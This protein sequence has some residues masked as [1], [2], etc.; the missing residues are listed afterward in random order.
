MMK[1]FLWC[2][3]LLSINLYAIDVDFKLFNRG[4]AYNAEGS[5]YSD[6]ATAA[7]YFENFTETTFGFYFNDL[8][9]LRIGVAVF[10]PFSL[11]LP[12]GMR[13]F[14]IITSQI[15]NQYV[16]FTIGTMDSDHNFPAPL[17]DPLITL[18]P[19]VR[20][21]EGNTRIPN[22]TEQ[23]D[24]GKF[25][26]GYY[27]YGASF[28]WFKGGSGEIFMNWQ[29]LH[30]EEHR[31][32]FDVGLIYALDFT[33]IF[34]PYVGVRYWH[35]GGK[36]YPIVE[37]STAI[38][39]NYSGGIGIH[40]DMLSILYLASFDS[41]TRDTTDLNQFGHGLYAR[42]RFS[43]LGW[44]DLE[45]SVFV[46]GYYLNKE[47][48][49]ISIEADPFFRVPFYFGLNFYK[50]FVFDNGIEIAIQF[51]NGVFLTENGEVGARYDQGINFDFTYLLDITK[52]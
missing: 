4:L 13:F 36:E 5:S 7:T 43:I 25:T 30:T 15:S 39:E 19:Y 24:Y 51:I 21:A 11:E 2:F 14:P 23:F 9:S 29:L 42:F 35:N 41:P 28:E 26:H 17:F 8:I 33:P 40:S 52:N 44:F 3:I 48:K 37:G 1:H 6:T 18:T 46:S 45:P 34:T 12:D 27:E 16:S 22:S 49:Y 31:E 10:I 50:D 20:V 32:R 47:H 38:T